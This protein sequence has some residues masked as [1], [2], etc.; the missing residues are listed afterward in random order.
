[1]SV[2]RKPFEMHSFSAEKVI[3]ITT[4]MIMKFTSDFGGKQF[5]IPRDIG[6]VKAIKLDSLSKS[7]AGINDFVVDRGEV[8]MT[9][10]NAILLQSRRTLQR[11]MKVLVEMEL[12]QIIKAGSTDPRKRYKAII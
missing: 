3:E 9:E 8:S 1:M 4:V 2:T 5:T 11:N 7:A 12:I 10:C 6:H